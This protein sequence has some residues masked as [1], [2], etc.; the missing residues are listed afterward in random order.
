M[1]LKMLFIESVSFKQRLEGD[2]AVNKM[3][4]W[5]ESTPDREEAGVKAVR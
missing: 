4:V 3:N 5:K 1:I 2:E